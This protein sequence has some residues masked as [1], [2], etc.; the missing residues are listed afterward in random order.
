MGHYKIN[1]RE[2]GKRN[3]GGT[4]EVSQARARQ[5]DINVK[6]P[7]SGLGL[8]VQVRLNMWSFLW[9]DQSRGRKG[10]TTLE[11]G[12]KQIIITAPSA[13]APVFVIGV[14]HEKYD[15]SMEIISDVFCITNCLA[16]ITKIIHDNFGI[17]EG[18][19]TTVHAI[20]ATHK[21]VDG[22]SSKAWRDG[23]GA[24]QNVI[25]ASTGAAKAVGKVIPELNGKSSDVAFH[26][27]VAD[28]SV[29]HLTCQME[30]GASYDDIKYAVKSASE[31]DSWKGIL[32]YTEDAVVSSDLIGDSH[33]SIFDASVG[34][35]LNK[36][37]VKLVSCI[38]YESFWV[39][40]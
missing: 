3:K 10:K 8:P 7:D 11:S 30:K 28:V 32:G 17:V 31:S 36:N 23:R 21:T 27:P 14:N 39:Q 12:A 2:R 24:S 38:I 34:I 5:A 33:S 9:R 18:L 19:V 13:N 29:V 37:F 1:K 4:E 6:R 25:S 16:P 22:P 26:V 35:F 20:T 15:P 40:Q